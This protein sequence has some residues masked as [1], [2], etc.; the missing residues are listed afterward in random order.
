MLTRWWWSLSGIKHSMVVVGSRVLLWRCTM[1]HLVM[2]GVWLTPV[3]VV[4]GLQP[5]SAC[6][7]HRD[8][9]N[10][11]GITMADNTKG[12]C[13]SLFLFFNSR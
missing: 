6:K 12:N 7:H 8:V 10:S 3:L 13:V 4:H 11:V 1:M 5:V 2:I 9:F